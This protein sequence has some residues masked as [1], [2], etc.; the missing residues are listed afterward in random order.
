[1]PKK[2]RTLTSY[3]YQFKRLDKKTKKQFVDFLREE[4]ALIPFIVNLA[5]LDKFNESPDNYLLSYKSNLIVMAF[6]WK[7]SREKFEY[8]E[9]LTKKWITK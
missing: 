5:V 9:Y 3:L 7:K 2:A 6:D 8:W 4:N 1:M